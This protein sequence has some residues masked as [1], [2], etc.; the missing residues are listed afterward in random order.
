LAAKSPTQNGVLDDM[1]TWMARRKA[2]VGDFVR[3][4]ESAGRQAWNDATRKGQTVLARTQAELAELGASKL[5]ENGGRIAPD[6]NGGAPA[7]ASWPD[8][9]QTAKTWAESGAHIAGN[10]AGLGQGVW[11][12]AKGLGQG[13]LFAGRLLDP[14]DAE[15]NGADNSAWGQVMN[16]GKGVLDYAK[17]R[18]ANPASVENDLQNLGHQLYVDTV[19][20][21]TPTGGTFAGEMSRNYNLGRN[22]GELGWDVGSLLFGGAASKALRGLSSTGK[23]G[24][25]AKFL[26]QGFSPSQADYLAEPYDGMG[27]HF[28]QRSV[29]N[30]IGLPKPVT[31]SPFNVLKPNGMSR[32]DFY[33]LHYGVDPD[34]YGTGLGARAGG[35][36]WSGKKLG[37]PK[38]RLGA[39][40]WNGSPAPLNAAVGVAGLVGLPNYEPSGDDD[41]P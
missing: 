25:A 1:E 10:A 36:G 20:S 37:L 12:S 28:V 35:G 15:E 30:T 27:H 40:L 3:N 14:Y 38:Y 29:A 26:A 41:E 17:N 39:S 5:R 13:L 19:S 24:G 31:D 4:A 7:V 18:I 11:H 2:E 33:E 6:S 22:Q 34:F 8:Q 16:A 9:N 21:A 23:S 32:G